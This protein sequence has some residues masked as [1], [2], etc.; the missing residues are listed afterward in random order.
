[1]VAPHPEL[2]DSASLAQDAWDYADKS[3][4]PPLTALYEDV[5]VETTS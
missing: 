4:E 1:M 3:P 2:T 5:L